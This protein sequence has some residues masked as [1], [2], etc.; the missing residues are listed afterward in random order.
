M[1]SLLPICALVTFIAAFGIIQAA[2]PLPKDPVERA[3]ALERYKQGLALYSKGQKLHREKKY[4][5]ANA[6]YGRAMAL[7]QDGPKPDI[8][9]SYNSL[10][11]AYLTK[12]P[13]IALWYYSKALS[14][15]LQEHGQEHE[16][17]AYSYNHVGLACMKMKEYDRAI[18]YFQ[19]SMGIFQRLKP[20][21]KNANVAAG[22]SYIAS[23]HMAKKEYDE[24][25]R[26]YE[27]ALK[28]FIMVFGE[29][30]PVIAQAKR[31]LG[32]ALNKKG[33][34]KKRANA[35]L[36]EAKKLNPELK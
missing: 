9:N 8:A 33:G 14:V 17:V 31:D 19:G 12:K 35:L 34:D 15:R 29:Q 1:K 16:S 11:N 13:S 30:H 3:K 2:K 6:T 21:P 24:A 18:A 4:D 22:H 10:G 7:F 36:L 32:Q 23:V 26:H 5:E 25:V 20:G 27:K 28:V